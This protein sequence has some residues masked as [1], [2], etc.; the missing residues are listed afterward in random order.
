MSDTGTGTA[1]PWL[2]SITDTDIKGAIQ[3][4]GWD[5]LPVHEAVAAATKSFRDTQAH[6]GVPAAELLRLP[7]AD[8]AA[9]V[10]AFWER[11]GA[12][13][14][15]KGYAF[16]GVSFGDTD[17]DARFRDGFRGE[18]A[19]LNMP[20]DMAD[21]VMGWVQKNITEVNKAQSDIAAGQLQ[22]EQAALDKAW[23]P[24]KD[25]Y[26]AMAKTAA[27]KLGQEYADGVAAL[28]G[29]VGYAKV[30]DMFRKL[31]EMTGEAKFFGGTATGQEGPMNK[32]Q[33]SARLSELMSDREGWAKRYMAGGV[34]EKKQFQALTSI[35]AAG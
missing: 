34:D 21:R 7:K 24:R 2:D 15:A 12:P 26:T 29:K 10:K 30:L 8:D 23:G 31:G 16:E 6:L 25:I 4:A 11:L 35:I 9:A 27:L 22:E 14:E 19:A 28:E 13:K 17:L 1:T 33:A 18:A 20:K 32:D 5:K 3:N